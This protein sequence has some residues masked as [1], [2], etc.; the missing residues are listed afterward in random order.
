M[1]S[2]HA[3][4][5]AD[6]MAMGGLKTTSVPGAEDAKRL[7]V[8]IGRGHWG[9]DFEDHDCEEGSRANDLCASLRLVPCQKRVGYGRQD[10]EGRDQR[11]PD[12]FESEL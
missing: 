2:I 4:I 10:R 5:T 6:G 3:A 7:A 12:S 11:C 8:A 9:Q 1:A